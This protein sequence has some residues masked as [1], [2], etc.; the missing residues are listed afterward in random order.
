MV[1]FRCVVVMVVVVVCVIVVCTCVVKVV[2]LYF[3]EGFWELDSP[4]GYFVS[5]SLSA[6]RS[7]DRSSRGR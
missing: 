6:T 1:V 2:M 7:H 4:Y 5:S 3:G